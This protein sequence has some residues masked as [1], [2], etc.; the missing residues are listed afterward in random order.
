M[1]RFSRRQLI[2]RVGVLAASATFVPADQQAR[3]S[4][5]L[6]DSNHAQVENE[7][8][9]NQ[10]LDLV[11][12]TL[13]AGLSSRNLK[14]AFGE[15]QASCSIELTNPD[16]QVY[17]KVN[18]EGLEQLQFDSETREAKIPSAGLPRVWLTPDV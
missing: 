10:K 14:P 9:D 3:A 4:T 16:L 8:S 1:N 18:R 13:E 6:L 2:A 12:A 7:L 5:S 17:L 15:E 11:R